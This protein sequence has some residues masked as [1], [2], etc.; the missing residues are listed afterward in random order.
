VCSVNAGICLGQCPGPKNRHAGACCCWP[1]QV[2]ILLSGG[3]LPA[4]EE[5]DYVAHP[6]F[7][8]GFKLSLFLTADHFAAGIDNRKAGD[9]AIFAEFMASSK[10]WQ[11]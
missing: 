7:R 3:R 6:D 4:L 10:T 11:S 9:A 5:V 1:T 2:A 8:R